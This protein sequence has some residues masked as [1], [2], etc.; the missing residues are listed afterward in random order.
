MWVATRSGF[1]ESHILTFSSHG[2]L[3]S[4][5]YNLK[6]TLW[7]L[8]TCVFAATLFKYKYSTLGLRR[9]F[10]IFWIFWDTPYRSGPR[11]LNLNLL[12]SNHSKLK[13]AVVAAA[14]TQHRICASAWSPFTGTVVRSQRHYAYK[15]REVCMRGMYSRP[16]SVIL[17]PQ[18]W[19]NPFSCTT[20][21]DFTI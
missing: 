20:I 14:I 12:L 2:T 19:V 1:R 11:S 15:W 10:D 17:Q 3:H 7:G 18:W 16:S 13:V 5:H 9:R 8:R 21:T 6:Q 4:R